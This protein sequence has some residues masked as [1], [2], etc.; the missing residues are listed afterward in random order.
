MHRTSSLSVIITCCTWWRVLIEIIRSI[1]LCNTGPSIFT[2]LFLW[3]SLACETVFPRLLLQMLISAFINHFLCRNQSIS[4]FDHVFDRSRPQQ[5]LIRA[6]KHMH[7]EL[8]ILIRQNFCDLHVY[9]TNGFSLLFI[10]LIE[11]FFVQDKVVLVPTA[12]ETFILLF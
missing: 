10:K 1:T 2:I 9:L 11:H 8:L 12:E 4:P 3:T 6:I 5:Y 7:Y